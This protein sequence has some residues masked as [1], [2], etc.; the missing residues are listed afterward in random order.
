MCVLNIKNVSDLKN[1]VLSVSSILVL[2]ID[3]FFVLFCFV[4]LFVFAFLFQ[5]FSGRQNVALIVLFQSLAVLT[6]IIFQV[7]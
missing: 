2:H 4:C 3:S 6:Y 5:H 1:I 7:Q